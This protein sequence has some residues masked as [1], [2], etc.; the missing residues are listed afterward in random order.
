MLGGQSGGQELLIARDGCAVGA[1]GPNG[2]VLRAIRR[3]RAD[4]D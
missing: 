4:Y 2:S 1:D 3:R